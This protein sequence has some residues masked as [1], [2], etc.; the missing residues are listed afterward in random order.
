[1]EAAPPAPV[2]SR[3][4]APTNSDPYSRDPVDAYETA[5]A[6]LAAR[7][8]VALQLI[9]T[10]PGV[11]LQAFL[12]R[13]HW[14]NAAACKGRD[15][16]A[17]F[18][19]TDRAEADARLVCARCAVLADCRDWALAQGDA[20]DGVYGGLSADDR[21]DLL[22]PPRRRAPRPPKPVPTTGTGP[23]DACDRERDL[24]DI[25]AARICATCYRVWKTKQ[26]PTGEAFARW[27]AERRLFRIAG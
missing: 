26:R 15:T 22:H 1:M 14:H 9:G 23:C 10:G 13:P 6:T 25:P 17:F 8:A 19:Q 21:Y 3:I 24:V 16:A 5:V 18:D 20:L 4:P 27:A 12:N 2:T 7:R 11:T